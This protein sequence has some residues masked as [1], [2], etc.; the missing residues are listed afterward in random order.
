[1]SYSSSLT[2]KEWEILEPLLPEVLPKKK[3]TKP[4]DWSYRELIDGVLY[5]LKNGC[6]WEDLPKDLPPYSTV[7]WHYKQWRA[8]GT[9]EKLMTILHEQARAQVKKKPKWTTLIIIDSQA[10][11]NTCNASVESKGFYS[12]KATNGIKRHLAVD[13]LGF[14]FFTICT[15]ASVSDDT[16][17]IAL[18]TQNIDYFRSK[19]M[20]IPKITILLDH[21]YHIDKL[22]AALEKVYPQIMRKIRFERSPKPTKAEKAAAGKS[23]FVP[24]AARWV[25]ERSNAWMERCKSLVKNFERTLDN[26]TTQLNLCFVRLMLKRL[27]ANP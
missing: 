22:I 10:V 21:G 2:D 18:L 7:Y 19:P 12:Y 9:I 25:I 23:G 8:A 1:M 17:L 3:K 16:G 11:K 24:A 4:L 26:A 15:K 5:R 20:N 6:N 14:P 13:I 27:A